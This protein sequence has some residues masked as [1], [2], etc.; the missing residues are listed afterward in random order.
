MWPP[1]PPPVKTMVRDVVISKIFPLIMHIYY[2][3]GLS[4]VFL[5]LEIGVYMWYILGKLI[6]ALLAQREII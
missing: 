3:R 6:Y 4:K 5:A 2:A 1:V